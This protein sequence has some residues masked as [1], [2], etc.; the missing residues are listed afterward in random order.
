[1]SDTRFR[2][3]RFQFSATST[4]GR[5]YLPDVPGGVYTLEDRIRPAGVKVP[6]ATAISAGKYEVVLSWSARFGCVLPLLLRVP[7]FEGIRIHAGNASV[8]TE[9]CILVGQALAIDR[10][11][12]S[13]SALATLLPRLQTAA[14]SGKVWLDITEEPAGAEMARIYEGLREGRMP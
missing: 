6:G 9:G 11:V 2:L 4:I 13:R 1:M 12:N 10:V 5:L 3:T 14:K 8:D 7:S